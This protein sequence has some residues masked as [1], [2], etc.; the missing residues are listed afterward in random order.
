M[1]P[2]ALKLRLLGRPQVFLHAEPVVD[3]VSEKALGLLCYLAVR[4]GV[5][6]RATL[7]N[8][9]WGEMPDRRAKANLRMA[10]YNLQ[11]LLPGYFHVTR[12]DVTFERQTECWLD[13]EQLQVEEYRLKAQPIEQEAATSLRTLLDLYRGDFLEG[14]DLKDAP[15]LE[16]WLLTERERL[17]QVALRSFQR[18]ADRLLNQGEYVET[19]AV[20]RR[21]LAL[22]PWREVSHRQLMLALARTGDYTGALAQYALC[23][24]VLVEE[25]GVEPM[26]ETSALD[27]RIRIARAL[28]IR[29]NLPPPRPLL[30]GRETELKTLTRLLADPAR[31]MVTLVGPGGIG[32]TRLALSAARQQVHSFLHGVWFVPLASLTAPEHLPATIGSALQFAFTGKDSPKVQLLRYLHNQEL[33]LVLDNFEHLLDGVEFVAELLQAVPQL[34]LLVTSRERLNLQEEWVFAVTGLAYPMD[35]T[36]AAWEEYSAVRLFSERAQRVHAPFRLREAEKS[37]LVRICQL[38]E[39]MPLGVEMAA[40]WVGRFTCSEIA[41]EIERSLG[42]LTTSLRNIPERHRSMRA[43]FDHSWE[44]LSSEEQRVLRQLAVLR[45]EF[46]REAAEQIALAAR[47]TLHALV[48]KS[49][50]RWNALPDG[51]QRYEFHELIRQYAYERLVEYRENEVVEARHLC[52]FLQLAERSEPQLGGSEQALWLARLEREHDNL[53]AALDWSARSP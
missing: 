25:L 47:A 27:T 39:G 32:K 2:K 36:V 31:R 44:L 19:I 34:K 17:R 28:P 33:L 26:P 41:T 1:Q 23:R 50:L 18:L 35:E 53:R 14:F 13:V 22:E 30:V 24:R 15:G 43:V 3:F 42:F 37:A 7:A 48:D 49:L 8:L 20:L 16:E 6:A 4:D 5:H 12:L 29:H 46:S 21:L 45:G 52:F 38:V 11:Q 9:L 10:I 51:T 40:T